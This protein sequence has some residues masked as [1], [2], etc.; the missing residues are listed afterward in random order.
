MPGGTPI[1][2]ADVT[3]LLI[4]MKTRKTVMLSDVIGAS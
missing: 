4:D 2:R 3:A 1:A